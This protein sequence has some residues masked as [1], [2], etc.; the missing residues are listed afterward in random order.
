MSGSSRLA[1]LVTQAPEEDE[2]HQRSRQAPQ[3]DEPGPP[4]SAAAHLCS[5]LF[6][7]QKQ[8]P[9]KL[10]AVVPGEEKKA[11]RQR[12][13]QQEQQRQLQQRLDAPQ[14]Q[15][16]GAEQQQVAAPAAVRASAASSSPGPRQPPKGSSQPGG[17]TEEC[18]WGPNCDE[19]P[20]LGPQEGPCRGKKTLVLDLDET[21]V[22]SSFRATTNADIIITV[23]LEGEHHKVF[24][25]K[26]PGVDEFLVKVAEMFEVVVY[27]AS[28]AKYANPLLDELDKSSTVAYRL[29]REACT[30]HNSGYVKDLS[31][32]GRDLGGVII[33]D[34]SPVCY[35][36]QPDN[37]IP[38]RTWRDDVTDRELLEL[39]PIL[40]SLASVE[41]IPSVLKQIVWGADEEEDR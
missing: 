13:R 34:N 28:M 12:Q 15:Q 22:H 3:P 11:A 1:D 8:Q 24:V 14:Q 19:P 41:D 39:I 20:Q 7:G 4:P 38:I 35:A 25:R 17:W 10:A 18:V 9:A 37:A 31:K 23:E 29:F 36:L 16:P 40:Y 33:I 32:L 27:T 2:A 26:R 21:L 6:G 5:C 30:R